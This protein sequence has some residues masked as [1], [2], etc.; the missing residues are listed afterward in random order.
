MIEKHPHYNYPI[1]KK[2]E[3]TPNRTDRQ[4]EGARALSPAPC[5]RLL[6]DV[7]DL[8]FKFAQDET[9]FQAE[10]DVLRRWEPRPVSRSRVCG[11]PRRPPQPANKKPR[12]PGV[13]GLSVHQVDPHARRTAAGIRTRP[14]GS[15]CFLAQIVDLV[16]DF[17]EGEIGFQDG[18]DFFPD[19]VQCRW[20]EAT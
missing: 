15:G 10:G 14:S 7:H 18:R 12:V 1:R 13:P 9:A 2:K 19:W 20:F 6:A 5:R 16:G 17:I 8:G 4:A 3:G 11:Y